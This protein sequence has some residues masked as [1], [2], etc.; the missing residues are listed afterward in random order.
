VVRGIECESRSSSER[1]KYPTYLRKV[2]VRALNLKESWKVLLRLAGTSIVMLR[3]VWQQPG[4][5]L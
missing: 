5:I 1:E 2:V 4:V 3:A